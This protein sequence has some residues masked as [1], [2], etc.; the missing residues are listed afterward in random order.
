MRVR[1]RGTDQTEGEDGSKSEEDFSPAEL[2]GPSGPW[3]QPVTTR[4]TPAGATLLRFSAGSQGVPTTTYPEGRL[5]GERVR[6]NETESEGGGCPI[7]ELIQQPFNQGP[8]IIQIYELRSRPNQN[9]D[10]SA[11]MPIYKHLV[12]GSGGDLAA[13]SILSLGLASLWRELDQG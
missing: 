3:E 9:L 4:E 5:G 2:R 10:L 6:V 1:N 11:R 13:A 7:G 12:V 8:Y